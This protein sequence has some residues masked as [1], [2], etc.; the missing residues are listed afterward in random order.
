MGSETFSDPASRK[1][2]AGKVW[3]FDRPVTHIVGSGTRFD[4]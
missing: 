1:V 4:T 3:S 2:E